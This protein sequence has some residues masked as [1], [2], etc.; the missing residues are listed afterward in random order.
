MGDVISMEQRGSMWDSSSW[1]VNRSDSISKTGHR[2][3]LRETLGIS[4][5]VNFNS[6]VDVSKIL[7]SH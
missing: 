5:Q 1:N 4:G 3:A 7:K 6:S 2:S